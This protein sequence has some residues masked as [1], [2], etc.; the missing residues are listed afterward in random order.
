MPRWYILGAG[1]IGCL[2]ARDLIAAGN[3]VRLLL[4]RRQ[5]LEELNAMG[6]AILVREP[7]GDSKLPISAELI[8]ATSPIDHLLVTTKAYTTLPALD[9][10]RSRLDPNA[11]IV[12]LQNG[13]GQQE[14][15]AKAYPGTR[16]WAAST[17][18]G[19][20]RVAPFTIVPAG[21]GPTYV[22]RMGQN[23]ND[24]RTLPDGWDEIPEIHP[25]P[26]IGRILLQKLAINAAINPLTAIYD[27]RNSELLT[28][29]DLNDL[30]SVLCDEIEHI[31]DTARPEG[32]Q[33]P[34]FERPLLDKVVQVATTTGENYSSMHQDLR[35][36]RPTE[37]EQITGYLCKLAAQ[38]QC[39]A[40]LNQQLL[41]KI[42]DMT[43][44]NK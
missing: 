14:A 37:I 25:Y 6:Q 8:D 34:L 35:A 18:R 7:D 13:Y 15:V 26:Q 36:R 12:L 27:C 28:N 30:L 39:P 42:R 38:H 11:E 1:A 5:Q 10:I 40:P 43:R 2:F 31:L 33:M 22:G 4:Y 32:L 24:A 19:V 20:H 9:A 29:P 41:G 16:V 23:H 21:M 44:Q 17:V 3:D